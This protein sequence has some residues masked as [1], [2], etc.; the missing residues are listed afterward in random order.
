MEGNGSRSAARR[1]TRRDEADAS[2]IASV[3][4][5]TPVNEWLAGRDVEE[6]VGRFQAV[7]VPA[8]RM[9]RVAELPDSDYF[10]ERGFLRCEAHP[11]LVEPVTS[12]ARPSQAGRLQAPPK[13]PA[14]LMGEHSDDIVREWL[15]LEPDTIERLAASGV[16]ERASVAER[17]A[18]E[19]ALASGISG[20]GTTRPG[21]AGG[22]G[23]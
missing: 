9:L 23:R 18:I 4:G 11:F 13:R 15:A 14:P 3:C 10:G 1:L 16:I 20:N 21:S 8:A 5:G 17:R 19:D 6:A 2:A 22:R 12:E 7:G